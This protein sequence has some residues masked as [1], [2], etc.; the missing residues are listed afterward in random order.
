[1]I[2]CWVLHQQTIID[3][4]INRI[5]AHAYDLIN[6]SLIADEI[7]LKNRLL[8]DIENGFRTEDV[9]KRSLNRIPMYNHLNTIKVDTCNKTI[10]EI[11][12]EIIKIRT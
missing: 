6:I 12:D 8:K 10:N 2:F 7:T 11:V 9:M 5:S 3:E 4:I 1:M